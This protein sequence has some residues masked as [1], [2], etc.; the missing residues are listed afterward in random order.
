MSS[1]GAT[2][3]WQA[4]GPHSRTES[5]WLRMQVKL[6][7]YRHVQVIVPRIASAC[8]AER[9]DPVLLH[10]MSV[11]PFTNFGLIFGPCKGI[12]ALLH[13]R[14]FYIPDLQPSNARYTRIGRDT[15]T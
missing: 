14:L 9:Q 6:E 2:V 3:V 12:R 5:E 7:R 13:A 15:G 8:R 1:P 10:G 11:N 4:D